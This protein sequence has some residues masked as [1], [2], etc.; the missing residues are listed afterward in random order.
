MRN[1]LIEYLKPFI[2][3]I[4]NVL[5]LMGGAPTYDTRILFYAVLVLPFSPIFITA[6]RSENDLVTTIA[7]IH[8]VS[9]IVLNILISNHIKKIGQRW[10][11]KD[12]RKLTSDQVTF[13]FI[14]VIGIIGLLNFL[15]FKIVIYFILF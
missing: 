12:Y 7:I 10:P 5:N 9:Y 15:F 11:K 4:I 13:P 14:L 2:M 6:Y 3:A 8:F 1:R